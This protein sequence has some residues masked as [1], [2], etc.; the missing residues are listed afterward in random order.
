MRILRAIKFAARLD[1][2]VEP[3]SWQAVL[4]FRQVLDRA[5]PPRLLEEVIRMLRSGAAEASFRMMWESGVLEVILPEVAHNLS[6]SLDRD[7]EQDPDVGLWAYLR[8][9]DRSDRELLTNAVL[10]SALMIHAVTDAVESEPAAYGLRPASSTFSEKAKELLRRLVERLCLPKREVERIVQ[11]LA[12]QKHLFQLHR[13]AALP[14]ALMRRVYFPEALDLF[15]IGVRASRK[16]RRTLNRLRHAFRK[17]APVRQ[18]AASKTQQSKP[19]A[20]ARKRSRSSS[21]RRRRHKPVKK[22]EKE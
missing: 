5:A 9:I 4:G 11:L 22:K 1:F 8:A 10:L 18:P 3:D 16:G 19:P 13:D 2:E 7:E 15:E 12:S 20:R 6:R 17:P 21:R 14:R